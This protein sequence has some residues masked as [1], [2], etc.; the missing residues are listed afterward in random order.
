[1]EQTPMNQS[2]ET[3]PGNYQEQG[4]QN[5]TPTETKQERKQ[6]GQMM[7]IVI[8]IVIM[9]FGGLYFW[10]ARLNDAQNNNDEIPLILGDDGSNITP[11]ETT[12]DSPED[13]EADFSTTDIDDLSASIEADLSEIEKELQ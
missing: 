3:S 4:E 9:V 1:M 2:P 5:H 6:M 10:G 12:N 11:T 7:G 13:I 8:I